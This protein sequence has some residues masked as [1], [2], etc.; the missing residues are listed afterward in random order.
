MNND[1][2]NAYLGQMLVKQGMIEN[3]QTKSSTKKQ[4]TL[5][6]WWKQARQFEF[7]QLLPSF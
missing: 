3:H 4:S 5:K 7:K 6:N 1:F 2:C